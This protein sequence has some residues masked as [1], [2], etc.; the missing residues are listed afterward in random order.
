M[1]PVIRPGSHQLWDAAVTRQTLRICHP[2]AGQPLPQ[3]AGL[4]DMAGDDLLAHLLAEPLG[5]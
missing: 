5:A 3:T 1:R 4:A 2:I